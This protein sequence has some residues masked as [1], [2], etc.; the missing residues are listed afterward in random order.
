MTPSDTTPAGTSDHELARALA[1]QAGELLLTLR[2]SLLAEPGVEPRAAG[3]LA[4]AAAQ[5]LLAQALRT[6]RPGDVVLS[7]E[8]VDDDVRLSADR[9]WIIDPL[10]GTREF[11]EGERT[12]WG[13]H[14]ALWERDS[15]GGTGPTGVRG[16]SASLTAGAVALPAQGITLATDVPPVVPARPV[17]DGPWRIV[18]SRSRPPA[19]LEQLGQDLALEVIPHGSAGAKAAEVVLGRADAYLH[20]S[21]AD[22]SG[23]NQWDAAAPVAVALAA[24]LHASHLD[25]SPFVFN[26]PSAI[27]GDIL[28]CR[29]ELA[30]LLLPALASLLARP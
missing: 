1:D 23:L 26:A 10:D 27:S 12:D 4:D 28:I 11:T 24:G 14:V 17:M 5:D 22:G 20:A 3:K 16:D 6:H 19:L 2:P 13:V 30:T 29:P 7:E 8:A 21:S 25:G 18:V 15:A 9:V